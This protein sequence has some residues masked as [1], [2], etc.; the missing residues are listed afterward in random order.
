MKSEQDTMITLPVLR[1]LSCTCRTYKQV[2]KSMSDETQQEDE[3]NITT[4]S[5]GL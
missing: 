1:K 5:E 3:D 4:T 2:D